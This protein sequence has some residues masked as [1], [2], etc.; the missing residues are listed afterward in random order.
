MKIYQYIIPAIFLIASVNAME[1]AKI[2]LPFEVIELQP[3]QTKGTSYEGCGESP[4]YDETEKV[5]YEKALKQYLGIEKGDTTRSRFNLSG[6]NDDIEKQLVD[7]LF[8]QNPQAKLCVDAVKFLADNFG[9]RIEGG[10]T[11]QQQ[12]SSEIRANQSTWCQSFGKEALALGRSAILGGTLV[13]VYFLS[14]YVLG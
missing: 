8:K 11:Q 3:L 12:N 10:F 7:L 9:K 1:Q 2:K 4:K 14:K 5:E 13:S 6:E